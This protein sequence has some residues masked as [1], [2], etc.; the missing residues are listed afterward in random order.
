MEKSMS[1]EGRALFYAETEKKSFMEQMK[2]PEVS[3]AAD[4]NRG[5]RFAENYIKKF[6]L[7]DLQRYQVSNVP[8]SIMELR[9][10]ENICLFSVNDITFN[11]EENI[12]DKLSNVYSS[13]HSLGLSLI[14]LIHSDGK[15][16]RLYLGIKSQTIDLE[17]EKEIGSIFEKAFSGNFPGS[18]ISLVERDK[19]NELIS[20]I[21][22]R[23]GENAVTALTS[24]PALKS[25]ENQNIQYVQ[26]IEKFI[27]TMKNEV[28]SV[29][30]ISDPISGGQ[31]EEVKHGYE[32][33]YT[34]LAPLLGYDLTLGKNDARSLTESEMRGYNDAIGSSVAKT[35]SFSRGSSITKS[36]STANTFGVGFGMFGS[37]G[38]NRSDSKSENIVKRAVNSIAGGPMKGVANVL[39]LTGGVNAGINASRSKTEG[40]A[41]G[42]QKTEQT[43]SQNSEQKTHTDSYQSGKQEGTTEGS[44]TSVMFKYENRSV[45]ELLSMIDAHLKRLGVCESYGM[46][47]S[48]AY[49]VSPSKETSI[50]AAS[51]YKGII[52]GEG[53]SLEAPSINTWFRDENVV[54]I[55]KY[56]RS[57]SHPRFHDKD[58]LMNTEA[59]ADISATTMISTKELSIQCNIPY[60]SVVG[61]A[62]REMAEFGRNI[63]SAD[64]RPARKI[65]IGDIYH[66]GRREEN[67]P[68]EV[69]IERLKEHTFVTG[70]TGSGKSNTVYEIISRLNN[71]SVSHTD[72][73]SNLNQAIPTLIIEPAKGE[74]K[75]I[76]QDTFHVFGTNSDCTELLKVNPFQFDS[77]IHVL[78]HIDR[79][80]D[81]FNVCWPM[82]A[83]MPAVLKE[84]VER[85]Y[86]E[87]GWDLRTSKNKHEITIY[88]CFE[89]LLSAL[90]AVIS[91]SDYSQE[92]KDNYTG[93][94]ITRVK[95]LTNGFYKDIFCAYEDEE[96]NHRLYEESAIVDLSR[97]GSAETKSMI[98]GI[99]L[100]RLQE[101]RMSQGG[102]N[103]NLK[104]VTVLEEAHNLL[105]RTSTEQ[106]S[107]TSNLL[108]KSVEMVAN[109][110]AEMRTY[111]EGFIIVDQAPGLLDLS[112]IRNTNTK[113][114]LRLPDYSDRELVGRAAGLNDKQIVELSRLPS[115]VAAIY[116]NKWIEP[117]LCAVDYYDV[118]PREY[119]KKTTAVIESEKIL[120][121]HIAQ[122]LLSDI[123]GEEPI[124]DVELL[125]K[126]LLET[127]ISSAF[128]IELYKALSGKKPQKLDD[129]YPLISK[130]MENY[131]KAFSNSIDAKDIFEWNNLLKRELELKASGL[132]AECIDNILDCMIHQMSLSQ[133]EGEKYEWWARQVGRRG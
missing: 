52:N 65:R 96:T 6:Y 41:K 42:E 56:L 39:G 94:L 34:E 37:I 27:D 73:T 40:T 114:I 109:A 81:I 127:S 46:W 112:V 2:N 123:T 106:N 51:A 36:E 107:E 44:S 84:A 12:L 125:K 90:R 49:F 122:Y 61:I 23:G 118:K 102:M 45:K 57:F 48:A 25:D 88:P 92:V 64:E 77:G 98:M 121:E 11:K 108:G 110:I 58:Y 62:V 50:I 101:R 124:T 26:G 8:R 15:S 95:S 22:P 133:N 20:D 126:R 54:R 120:K 117:V 72:Q 105:K 3:V 87:A 66:M 115:G 17:D 7:D 1:D 119:R 47:A 85:A 93:S 35:Q 33:L 79:L 82:Y 80:I 13:L 31:I 9:I 63:Y 128:K 19:G 113:I 116:Q 91:S 76:F 53:T 29:L 131:D 75:T 43:G 4:T 86:V 67:S 130:C 70:S 21:F 14:F 68:V 111:G 55:N 38:S 71:M 30:I 129:I 104:H 5:L 132:S 16:V 10:G 32:E 69:D 99:L 24:L 74:Y 83:A 89:D 78:E 100:I 18:H 60:K 97:I 103:L 59:V 28:Y